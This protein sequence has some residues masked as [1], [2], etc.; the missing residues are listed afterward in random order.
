M[1]IIIRR[2]NTDRK[3]IWCRLIYR[4]AVCSSTIHCAFLTFGYGL[5]RFVC[6]FRTAGAEDT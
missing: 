5:I 6:T 3:G 1:C 4:N 2:I